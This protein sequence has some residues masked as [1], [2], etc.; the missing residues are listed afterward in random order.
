MWA[1]PLPSSQS[2][3]PSSA[4]PT[5]SGHSQN[6]QQI[7]LRRDMK[8]FWMIMSVLKSYIK[9]PGIIRN[10]KESLRSLVTTQFDGHRVLMPLTGQPGGT[11]PRWSCQVAHEFLG[12]LS[13]SNDHRS[14]LAFEK[15]LGPGCS[16]LVSVGLSMAQV[17]NSADGWLRKK[18]L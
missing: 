14:G 2:L 9:L 11:K 5:E 8:L 7:L 16:Q 13:K 6:L 4:S 10:A 18:H 17:H 1:S 3:A 15:D 12:R